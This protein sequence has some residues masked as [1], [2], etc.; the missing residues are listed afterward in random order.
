MIR[1]TRLNGSNLVVNA[2]LIERIETTPDT[3]IR[4]TTGNQY[5]V[6]ETAEEVR[7]LAIQFLH[8]IRDSGQNPVAV[9]QL[10]R[11]IR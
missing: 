7:D 10:A 4:L 9:G 8:D 6:R 1:L 3:V 5:V 11:V 2:L